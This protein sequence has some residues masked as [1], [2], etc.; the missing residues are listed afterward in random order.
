MELST[1]GKS[2]SRITAAEAAGLVKAGDWVDYGAVLSQPH[3][4][5]RALANRKAELRNVK[6]RACLSMRPRAVLE[7]DPQREH[8]HWYNWHF[9]AYDRRKHDAGLCHY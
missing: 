6:I 4:F 1:H 7:A 2:A 3:A 5:G 9:G 8:F